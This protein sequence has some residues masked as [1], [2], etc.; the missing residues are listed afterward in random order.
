M[1]GNG[2]WILVCKGI[3][4]GLDLV[5]AKS[6]R[7]VPR[8]DR[9]RDRCRVR[10]AGLFTPSRKGV[11][12]GREPIWTVRFFITISVSMEPARLRCSRGFTGSA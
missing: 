1:S 6:V 2:S 9:D 10:Y 7:E 4:V 8:S 3:L 11:E 12:H 5:Y